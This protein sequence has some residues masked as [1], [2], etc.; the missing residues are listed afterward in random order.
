MDEGRS[1]DERHEAQH[2]AAN[3]PSLLTL[4]VHATG[5]TAHDDEVA[6]VLPRGTRA[7]SY[8]SVRVERG[9]RANDRAIGGR[10]R[11]TSH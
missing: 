3:G 7:R 6:A 5:K 11:R 10:A 1:E 9:N 8:C 2:Q 4:R